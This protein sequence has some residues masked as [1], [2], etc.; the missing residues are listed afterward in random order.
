MAKVIPFYFFFRREI[1]LHSKS[2]FTFFLCQQACPGYSKDIL[3]LWRFCRFVRVD[4]I[5]VEI[6]KGWGISD[7]SNE[8]PKQLTGS[9]KR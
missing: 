6:G 3:C 5:S 8:Y 1:A 2:V 9:L 7:L 4:G